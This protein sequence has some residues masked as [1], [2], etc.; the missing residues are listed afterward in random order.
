MTYL[1]LGLFIWI[2]SFIPSINDEMSRGFDA[3]FTYLS[4][5]LCKGNKERGLQLWKES[6]K[7]AD[8]FWNDKLRKNEPRAFTIA[9]MI[10]ILIWPV[11]VLAY[12]LSF[13]FHID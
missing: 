2:T 13:K 3:F 6:Q 1:C 8:K 9:S 7:D 12:I 5:K 11:Y 10:V 4:V